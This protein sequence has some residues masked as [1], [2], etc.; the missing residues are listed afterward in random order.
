MWT[1]RS[2]EPISEMRIETGTGGQQTR[3]RAHEG[4]KIQFCHWTNRFLYPSAEGSSNLYWVMFIFVFVVKA[5]TE[6]LAVL[7]PFDEKPTKINAT[8]VAPQRVA[9]ILPCMPPYKLYTTTPS[10]MSRHSEVSI[11]GGNAPSGN[12]T[13]M[14]GVWV[15]YETQRTISY[16]FIH[17]HVIANG[18]VQ[19][20]IYLHILFRVASAWVFRNRCQRIFRNTSETVGCKNAKDTIPVFDSSRA[21][22]AR[23]SPRS[24]RSRKSFPIPFRYVR[25]LSISFIRDTRYAP[26]SFS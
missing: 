24:L 23:A 7:T 3:R 25:S 6:T 20:E 15:K 12:F 10:R 11:A 13:G 4:T 2:S 17:T 8:A 21:T 19:I 26:I 5:G 16:V 22:R 9:Q 18:L 1:V 14:P